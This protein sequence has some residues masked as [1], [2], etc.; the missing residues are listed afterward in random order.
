MSQSLGLTHEGSREFCLNASVVA[1]QHAYTNK[2][3]WNDI[4]ERVS[5]GIPNDSYIGHTLT[6]ILGVCFNRALPPKLEAY[7][8]SSRGP[9]GFSIWYGPTDD[10][11]I[12]RM[13]LVVP[14]ELVKPLPNI[15]ISHYGVMTDDMP[16]ASLPEDFTVPDDHKIVTLQILTTSHTS[17]FFVSSDRRPIDM[18]EELIQKLGA[19]VASTHVDNPWAGA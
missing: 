14:A 15:L 9:A 5:Y 10:L 3:T 8:K 12:Y 19:V 2:P 11:T 16:D 17:R 13:D 4:I 18:S 7:L 6:L 1:D